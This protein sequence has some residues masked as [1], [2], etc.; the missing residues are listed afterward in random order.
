MRVWLYLVL[1]LAL[2][3]AA[4]ARLALHPHVA[5]DARLRCEAMLQADHGDDAEALA[6]LLP[7]CANRA[8]VT[9]MEVRRAG[10]PPQTVEE[11]LASAARLNA[12]S[13]LINL[14]LALAG[15]G[16]LAGAWRLSRQQRRRF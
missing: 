9:A 4:S 10:A 16:A 11:V 5:S 2:L 1:G 12:Q 13:A 14:A 15:I 8:M 7:R 6:L 3:A